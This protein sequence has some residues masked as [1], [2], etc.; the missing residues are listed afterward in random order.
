MDAVDWVIG[1]AVQHGAEIGL[2]VEVVELGG[3]DEGVHRSRAI[4]SG[5]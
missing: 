3:S 1:D 5:V 2:R 4:A